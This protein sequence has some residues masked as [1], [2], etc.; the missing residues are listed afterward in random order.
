[1]QREL[2]LSGLHYLRHCRDYPA[3]AFVFLTVRELRLSYFHP[4]TKQHDCCRFLMTLYGSVG[5]LQHAQ[6]PWQQSRGLGLLPLPG[7]VSPATNSPINSTRRHNVPFLSLTSTVL[8]GFTS[9][10]TYTHL[11]RIAIVSVGVNKPR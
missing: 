2:V 1:M 8:P 3:A 4:H 7:R 10:T 11:R 9:C 6:L 5:V